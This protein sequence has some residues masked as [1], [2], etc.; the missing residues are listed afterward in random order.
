M[1]TTKINRLILYCIQFALF[2]WRIYVVKRIQ[3]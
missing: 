2:L 1:E 3:Y